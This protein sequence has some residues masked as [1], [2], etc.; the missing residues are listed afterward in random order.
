MGV[1]GAE[2]GVIIGFA[3][4]GATAGCDEEL[5]GRGTVGELRGEAGPGAVVEGPDSRRSF[6]RVDLPELLPA[7]PLSC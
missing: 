3:F 4:D 1:K 2:E 7:L 6:R 5:G